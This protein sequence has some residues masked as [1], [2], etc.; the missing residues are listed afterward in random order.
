MIKFGLNLES[1]AHF[2]IENKKVKDGYNLK[3]N[4]IKAFRLEPT[5]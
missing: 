2:D 3:H 5:G 1:G 4:K